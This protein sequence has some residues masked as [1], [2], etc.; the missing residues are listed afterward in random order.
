MTGV[1]PATSHPELRP[2]PVCSVC[3]LYDGCLEICSVI[4]DLLPSP[5]R[6]RVDQEDLQRL[7]L[8]MQLT[9]ALLDNEHLLTDRQREIVRLYYRES[10]PQ[11]EIAEELHITQQAVNDALHRARLTVGKYLKEVAR[12]FHPAP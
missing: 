10:M 11:V 3:P 6:G 7:Y 2:G 4:E 8:G 9:R 1:Q 12:G 5:E